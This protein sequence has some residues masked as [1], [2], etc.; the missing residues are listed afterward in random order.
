[1]LRYLMEI[2]QSVFEGKPIGTPDPGT[3]WR[4]IEEYKIKVLFTAPT[5]FR[6]IKR[7][8]PKGE[9]IKKYNLNSLESLF[10]AGETCRSRYY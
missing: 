8:D 7:V 1:M 10:L 5:A 9:Y 6:A 2:R 3:F 4:V